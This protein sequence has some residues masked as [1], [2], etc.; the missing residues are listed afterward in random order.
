M[1]ALGLVSRRFTTAP[2]H[3]GFRWFQERDYSR[4]L[5]LIYH[6]HPLPK[7]ATEARRR[8]ATNLAQSIR[9][10]LSRAKGKILSVFV[11]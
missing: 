6:P 9:S 11:L 5:A 1:S 8:S 10:L 4:R 7:P 3:G 2:W